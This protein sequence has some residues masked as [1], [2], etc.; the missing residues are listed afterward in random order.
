MLINNCEER[1]RKEETQE[2]LI[3]GRGTN[4]EHLLCPGGLLNGQL[5]GL[6]P[7][8]AKG[9]RMFLQ[10]ISGGNRFLCLCVLLVRGHECHEVCEIP[11]RVPGPDAKTIGKLRQ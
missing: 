4:S 9:I 2:T 6:R 11:A 5:H 8:N 3:C 1:R 7:S 10:S